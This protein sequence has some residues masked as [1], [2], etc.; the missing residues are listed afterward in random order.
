MVMY[1]YSDGF[2]KLLHFLWIFCG[3]AEQTNITWKN[4]IY[5]CAM[6]MELRNLFF[7]LNQVQIM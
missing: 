3:L 1:K 6:R 2:L 4:I 5:L 7:T